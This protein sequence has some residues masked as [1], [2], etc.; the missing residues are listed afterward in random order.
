VCVCVCPSVCPSLCAITS[1]E[2][3]ISKSYKRILTNFRTV[4]ERPKDQSIRFGGVPD[5][6]RI[7]KLFIVQRGYHTFLV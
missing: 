3:N 6:I 7:Y 1:C 5:K 2:Q 4:E